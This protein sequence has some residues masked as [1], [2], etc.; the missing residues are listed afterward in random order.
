MFLF[1]N[2]TF[3]LLLRHND[4]TGNIECQKLGDTIHVLTIRD[5]NASQVGQ[6]HKTYK[7]INVIV[8]DTRHYQGNQLQ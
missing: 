2:L 1:Y 8:S 5:L 3:A 7:F 4:L 6:Y